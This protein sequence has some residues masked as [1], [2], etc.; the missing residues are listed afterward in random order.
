M[1]PSQDITEGVRN[2][3]GQKAHEQAT[4]LLSQ[5]NGDLPGQ[6]LGKKKKEKD[7]ICFVL[8]Q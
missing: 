5:A 3:Q 6:H 4:A 1:W 2:S 8:S 7:F